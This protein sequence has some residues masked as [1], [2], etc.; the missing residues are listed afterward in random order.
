MEHGEDA[1]LLHWDTAVMDCLE[2]HTEDR[3]CRW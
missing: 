2:P 1:E 3:S